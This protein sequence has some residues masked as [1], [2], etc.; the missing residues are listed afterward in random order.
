MKGDV[1]EE[2][3]DSMSSEDT[4]GRALKPNSSKMGPQTESRT[5]HA[6]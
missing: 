2:Q 3:A 5:D 4:E 1:L 6:N